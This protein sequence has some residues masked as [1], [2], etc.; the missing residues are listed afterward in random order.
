M[1]IHTLKGISLIRNEYGI[2]YCQISPMLMAALTEEQVYLEEQQWS[3]WLG[4]Q[5]TTS[6]FSCT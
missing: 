5:L 2:A 4:S 6:C 3:V 1:I